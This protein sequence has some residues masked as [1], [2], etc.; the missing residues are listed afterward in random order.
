MSSQN[1]QPS[2]FFFKL[3]GEGQAATLNP[4]L[5]WIGSLANIS[6]TGGYWV[7]IDS[8]DM[9]IISGERVSCEQ[10]AYDLHEGANLISYC[11]EQPLSLE[12]IPA[13]YSSIVGEGTASTYNPALGWIGSLIQL[14]PGKGYWLTC[15]EEVQ[16]NWDCTD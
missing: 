15:S 10:L 13:E 1:L 11:C 4:S 12:N 5:G 16:F 9:L 2:T 14:S 7:K 3:Y 8:E 6:P